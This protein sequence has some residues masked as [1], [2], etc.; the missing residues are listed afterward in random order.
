[1]KKVISLLLLT[2]LMLS[3]NFISNMSFAYKNGKGNVDKNIVRDDK[4]EIVKDLKAGKIY[5][6]A[7]ASKK[8]TFSDALRYC[9]EMD[10]LG[11]KDWKLP[12]I[13]ELKSLAELSRR[14]IYVKHAF[15]NI[16]KGIY[17]SST[18]DRHDESWYVDFD[19]GRWN[20]ASYTRKYYAVCVRPGE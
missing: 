7:S 4:K 18:I 3:A 1:M 20:T 16:Q 9:E 8:M 6:D 5:Y 10:Y 2:T 12:T 15:Q 17:W 11:Y 13:D 19:L 14:E